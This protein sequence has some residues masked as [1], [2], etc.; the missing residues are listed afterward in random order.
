MFTTPYREMPG[1]VTLK[2]RI[3]MEYSRAVLTNIWHQKR[4]AEPKDN[5]LNTLPVRNMHIATYNHIAADVQTTIPNSTAKDQQEQPFLE[6]P[7]YLEHEYP[8]KM[9]DRSNINVANAA[10]DGLLNRVDPQ[11]KRNVLPSRNSAEHEQAKLETTYHADFPP[12]FPYEMKTVAHSDYADKSYPKYPDKSWAYRKMVSHFT[13]LDKPKRTGINTFH[14]QHAQYENE[15]LRR[16]FGHFK[17][18]Q[19]Q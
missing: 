16:D 2:S 12:P 18:S 9:I 5:D 1:S 15:Q 8:R 11:L 19:F 7:W 3:P 14:V 13:D 6:R 4:E 10:L 17:P